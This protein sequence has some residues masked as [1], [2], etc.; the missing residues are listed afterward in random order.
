MHNTNIETHAAR[1]PRLIESCLPKVFPWA[2]AEAKT[3]RHGV[4]VGN[5]VLNRMRRRKE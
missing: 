1:Y 4:G 5:H 3:S 2:F